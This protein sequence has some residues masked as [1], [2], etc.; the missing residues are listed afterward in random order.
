[1]RTRFM[2]FA[3]ATLAMCAAT[4]YSQSPP[5]EQVTKKTMEACMAKKPSGIVCTPWG[6]PN[7]GEFQGWWFSPYSAPTDIPYRGGAIISE[8]LYRGIP[9][10]V[11]TIVTDTDQLFVNKEGKI[12]SGDLTNAG[13]PSSPPSKISPSYLKLIQNSLQ[14]YRK[15]AAH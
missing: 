9:G 14:V 11:I 13:K 4:A 2:G 7:K 5:A 12:I 6:K 10:A 3:A 15:L 8:D 1:M